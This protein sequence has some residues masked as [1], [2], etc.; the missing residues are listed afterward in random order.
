M[1]LRNVVLV[2]G[3]RS[4]FARGARGNLVATRLDDAGASVLRL[5]GISEV[6][7]DLYCVYV[8]AVSVQVLLLAVLNVF[9]YLDQRMIALSLSALFAVSN[10]AFTLISQE[11]GPS[12]YGYGFAAAVVLTAFS[13]L[14]LLS[15]K[16][17]QLEYETFMLKH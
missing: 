17:D 14:V 10:L 5:V 15:Q 11:L 3:A 9:F 16:F 1:Q 13:G 7:V 6:Y 8:A 12:F 4:A 2:D